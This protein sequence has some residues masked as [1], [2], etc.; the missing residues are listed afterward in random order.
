MPQ[1]KALTNLYKDSLTLVQAG[2]LFE[3]EPEF[4]DSAIA[5]GSAEL[6]PVK[7]PRKQT[8]Q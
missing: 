3:L 7:Q 8:E 5:D 1:L 2:E 6:V 4:V